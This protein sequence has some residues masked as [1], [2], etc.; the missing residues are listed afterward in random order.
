MHPVAVGWHL[1]PGG[2]DIADKTQ[3]GVVGEGLRPYPQPD[4]PW[5]NNM[6][7]QVIGKMKMRARMVCGYKIWRGIP[8]Q[9]SIDSFSY[10]C[11]TIIINYSI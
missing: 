2:V 9:E 6:M 8:G 7:E 1:S 3:V 11:Y 5:T 10:Y 4:V